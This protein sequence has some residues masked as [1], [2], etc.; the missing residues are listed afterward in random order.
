[1]TALTIMTDREWLLLILGSLTYIV[2]V[3][4]TVQN[5]RRKVVAVV[6]FETSSSTFD[7]K[8]SFLLTKN[9]PF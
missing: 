1:M 8:T 5:S 2:L 3:V 9:G 6:F 4:L 7:S